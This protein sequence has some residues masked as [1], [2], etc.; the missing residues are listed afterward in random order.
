MI[1]MKPGRSM[2]KSRPLPSLA[3]ATLIGSARPSGDLDEL[4]GWV[5]R[6]RAAGLDGAP[7]RPAALGLIERRG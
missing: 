6:K 4:D 1:R 2:T 3:A 7:T 5:A